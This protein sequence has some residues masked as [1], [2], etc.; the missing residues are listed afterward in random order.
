MQKR[1]IYQELN[2]VLKKLLGLSQGGYESNYSTIDDAFLDALDK[3]EVDNEYG[4]ISNLY[5][6]TD[7]LADSLSHGFEN[8]S[9]LFCDT[10]NRRSS[11]DY[12]LDR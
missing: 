5:W 10:S 4:I 1:I 11:G 12:Y 6:L 8:I 7:V 3:C 2:T 9:K